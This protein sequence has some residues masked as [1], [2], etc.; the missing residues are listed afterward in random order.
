[1]SCLGL[2]IAF[3]STPQSLGLVSVALHSDLNHDLVFII[4]VKRGVY[5]SQLDVVGVRFSPQ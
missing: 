3:V 4:Q 2:A 5:N 1:M